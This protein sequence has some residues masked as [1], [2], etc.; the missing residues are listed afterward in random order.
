MKAA[1]MLRSLN[2]LLPMVVTVAA[3]LMSGCAG[4]GTEETAVVVP[5]SPV[6]ALF[7]GNV[8]GSGNADGTGIGTRFNS[9]DA[10]ATDSAGNL[11][12]TDKYVYTIRK[13]T[14]AGVVTTLAG[15]A[16]QNGFTPGALPRGLST[17]AGIAVFGS[18]L[19]FTSNNGVVSVTNLP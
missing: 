15:T 16:G 7:A 14:P 18:A 12:V 2:C 6:M 3:L 9:P 19:Y 5:A 17:P 8:G 11:Y 4:D 10:V 13:I 1:K